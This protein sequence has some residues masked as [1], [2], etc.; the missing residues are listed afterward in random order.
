MASAMR[1]VAKFLF[2]ALA[3]AAPLFVA[4]QAQAGVCGWLA[5]G[6][7]SCE[8]DVTGGCEANCTPVHFEAQC[9]FD[10]EASCN[11]TADVDCEASCETD[12]QAHCTPGEIDCQADCETQC[13]GECDTYCEA[14]PGEANCVTTCKGNC[15][16][17]CS[18]HCSVKPAT[19]EAS[20]HSSCQ[21]S[22]SAHVDASCQADCHGGCSAKLT[23]GCKAD[24]QAPQGA[25]FCDGQ[26]VTVDN[27]D[28]CSAFV[29]VDA[30]CSGNKCTATCTAC[31][32]AQAANSPLDLAAVGAMALGCAVMVTRRR[33]RK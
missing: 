7:V 33:R 18:G 1:S 28:D 25:L 13:V 30:T 17:T 6:Q 4:N 5:D 11:V 14:H 16:T 9:G 26:Y 8:L 21:G 2:G 29:E 27:I 10:C 15:G 12:C 19:C 23:G 31:S 22:C 20:C 3:L 32:T 24:C